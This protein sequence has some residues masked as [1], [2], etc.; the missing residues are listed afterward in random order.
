MESSSEDHWYGVGLCREKPIEIMSKMRRDNTVPASIADILTMRLRYGDRDI[1]N[2][3]GCY[4]GDAV[5][6]HP[7]G[8]LKIVCDAYPLR[9]LTADSEM[10]HGAL[11]ISSVMYEALPGQEYNPSSLERHI[12]PGLFGKEGYGSD[13]LMRYLLRDESHLEEVLD[14]MEKYEDIMD[15]SSFFG[16]ESEGEYLIGC[17]KSRE[18]YNV[19]FARDGGKNTITKKPWKNVITMRPWSLLAI[20]NMTLMRPGDLNNESYY[21]ALKS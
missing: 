7:K 6:Y 16:Y 18:I 11:I 1:W 14:L 8:S 15:I 9:E 17:P 20:E 13:R 4:T 12:D 2:G 3:F 5:I 19:N 21:I 10:L